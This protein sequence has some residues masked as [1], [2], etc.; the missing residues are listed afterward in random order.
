LD[1]ILSRTHHEAI[2]S[3]LLEKRGLG[4]AKLFAEASMGRVYI[5]SFALTFLACRRNISA[6]AGASRRDV[7]NTFLNLDSNANP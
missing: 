4:L 3:L 7:E 5:V 2:G 1:G 6:K